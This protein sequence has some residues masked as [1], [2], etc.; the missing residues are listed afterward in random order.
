MRKICSSVDALVTPT[1][2]EPARRV[3]RI[4]EP[5]VYSG[6]SEPAGYSLRYTFP[7]NLTGQPALTVPCGFTSTGLPIG[8]Q[9][10]AGHFGELT[11]FRLGHAYQ[12]VTDWHTRVPTLH[13]V[14]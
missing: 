11:L 1:L 9:L 6:V 7:F 4:D 13:G 8:M 5:A 12:R 2:P 10:V 14:S 3:D